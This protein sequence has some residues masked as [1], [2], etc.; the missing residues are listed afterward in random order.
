MV[1]KTAVESIKCLRAMVWPYR[2]R[3]ISN[4]GSIS[5]WVR[6]DT[7]AHVR[8]IKRQLMLIWAQ[9]LFKCIHIIWLASNNFH[10]INKPSIKVFQENLDFKAE[11]NQEV[12]RT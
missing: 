6:V 3:V 12:E 2:M 1:L 4:L 9:D 8:I 10:K 5:W 7:K 11:R